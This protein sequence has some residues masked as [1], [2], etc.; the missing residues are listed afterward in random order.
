MVTVS[1]WRNA[2]FPKGV[3]H[4]PGCSLRLRQSEPFSHLRVNGEEDSTF[5][6]SSK[7]TFRPLF[8]CPEN[9]CQPLFVTLSQALG[10][11]SRRLI[12]CVC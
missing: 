7:A 6:T 11:Y 3:A 4:S 10:T 2:L 8:V 5:L 1:E 12:G 9:F